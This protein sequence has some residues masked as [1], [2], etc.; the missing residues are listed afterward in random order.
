MCAAIFLV[1]I[2]SANLLASDLSVDEILPSPEQIVATNN[3]AVSDA[4]K[5]CATEALDARIKAIHTQRIQVDIAIV[6]ECRERFIIELDE[7]VAF[8]NVQLQSELQKNEL[9]F[10]VERDKKLATVKKRLDSLDDREKQVRH[11]FEI[12]MAGNPKAD[13]K[14]EE[15]DLQFYLS[16]IARERNSLI[17]VTCSDITLDYNSRKTAIICSHFALYFETLRNYLNSI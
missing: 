12:F 9:W 16:A 1:L 4:D 6:H 14:R 11:P 3:S 10:F 5:I 2:M 17:A 15:F 8:L 13:I 7:I